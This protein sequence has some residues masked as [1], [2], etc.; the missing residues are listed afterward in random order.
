MQHEKTI[1]LFDRLS[2]WIGGRIDF[3][4]SKI[5]SRLS[6]KAGVDKE[7]DELKRTYHGLDSFL[8]NLN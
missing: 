3:E 2:R 4:E 5:N 6:I 8:V 7:L 1:D